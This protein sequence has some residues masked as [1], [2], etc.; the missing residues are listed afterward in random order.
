MNIFQ[1]LIQALKTRIL[2]I[3]T[4]VRLFF[5]AN[6]IRARVIEGIRTFFAKTFSIRPRDKD[7]YYPM[8]RWLVSKKLAFAVVIIIG[9][10]SL[11]Y[12]IYS[13]SAL[14]P[15]RANDGI[16]TYSYNNVL[17]K[18]AKGTVRIKG[19]SGYL[20]YEGEVEKGYCNG[21]GTLMNP[22]GHVVYQ[23]NFTNSM[24]E[25]EGTQYYTD[26]TLFYSGDFHENLHSG[27]GR[28]YRTN[29]SLEY[30]G[31]FS[32]DMK[33]G[34]G[35]LYDM[36][37]NMVFTGEFTIDE[38]KYSDFIGKSA[39]EMAEAYGGERTLY[40][41]D[42]ERVR[43]MPDIDAMTVEFLDE[44]SIDTEAFAESVFVL[45]DYFNSADGDLKSF[46][47]ITSLLGQP[48]YVGVSYATLPE[49][50][51]VNTLNDSSGGLI[52]NGEADIEMQSVY[53]EYIEVSDYDEEYEVYLH[54]YQKDGLIYTFVTDQGMDSFYFY[55]IIAADL[56]DV[57]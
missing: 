54:T 10:L 26:G 40:E 22:I 29:G 2:P 51:A 28:L 35:T 25:G 38:I 15:S 57:E 17:L 55:Y 50:L 30:E 16:K 3:V 5:S 36:G 37:H 11:V 42:T 41:S 47:E 24:Y 4:R 6:Y 21:N 52:I 43:Y 44:E 18:F 33:E 19:K 34:E 12:V 53:N 31:S 20:A 45:K 7:D 27:I 39:S 9:V 56:S 23:G 1:I 48:T 46:S 49:L 14:F 32:L 8:G 13:W